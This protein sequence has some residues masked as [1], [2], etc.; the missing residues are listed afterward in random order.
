MGKQKRSSDFKIRT[1]EFPELAKKLSPRPDFQ[2]KMMNPMGSPKKI[3]LPF[4]SLEYKGLL[5]HSEDKMINFVKRLTKY[6][7]SINKI[8]MKA[9]I[10][11]TT[12]FLSLDCIS[13]PRELV[14]AKAVDTKKLAPRNKTGKTELNNKS[15]NVQQYIELHSFLL[16]AVIRKDNPIHATIAM[17]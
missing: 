3:R 9:F 14:I 1:L 5:W 17:S 16:S 11:V 8:A 10:H 6:K 13:V 4:S 7:P 15:N 12:L 2:C